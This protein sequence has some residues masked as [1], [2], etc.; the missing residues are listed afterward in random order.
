MKLTFAAILLLTAPAIAHP[1]RPIEPGEGRGR[2]FISPMGEPFRADHGPERL[3]FDGADADHDGRITQ[4][5]FEA[6]A[7]RFFQAL[8][9][10]HD[11]EIDPNEIERY[12]TVIAPEIRER[13]RREAAD[14][15]ASGRSGGRGRRDG[16]MGGQGMHFGNGGSPKPKAVVREGAARFGY[17]DLPEPVV[18]ADRNGNRGIDRGEFT[19]TAD[20]RFAALDRNGDGAITRGE[21][22]RLA[23][24]R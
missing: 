10:N 1:S 16:G 6:D 20:Q 2:V 22:P 12:E 17:L 7:A 19:L 8:D 15:E 13:E 18:S 4:T 11:G 3:W 14:E 9:A 23:A 21:L 5:E 24:T